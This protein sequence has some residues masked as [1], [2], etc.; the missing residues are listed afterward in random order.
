M[1]D[2]PLL[3]G[4]SS[5]KG[6]HEWLRGE[7]HLKVMGDAGYRTVFIPGGSDRDEVAKWMNRADLF[8]SGQ[9][10]G[11]LT[12]PY[13][14][15]W[16]DMIYKET[17]R[18][19]PIVWDLDDNPDSIS[20]WNSSYDTF[21]TEEVEI[22]NPDTGVIRKLWEDGVSGFDLVRNRINLEAYRFMLKSADALTVPQPYLRDKVLKY[23]QNVEILPNY[24]D[25]KTH[26]RLRNK[27]QR[28]G[29][30]RILYMGGS[31]HFMDWKFIAPVMKTLTRQYPHIRVV[32]YGNSATWARADLGGE[33]VED[34]R[35]DGNYEAFC[36]KMGTLGV[37]IG[38]A[39]LNM[40]EHDREF[41]RCKSPLK[42]VDYGAV[43]IPCVAQNDHPYAPVINFG[44]G[45]PD[46]MWDG[47]LA[48]TH[49]DWLLALSMLIENP[50]LRELIGSNAY[51]TIYQHWN[52]ATKAEEYH[53]IYMRILEKAK[54]HGPTDCSEI[55]REVSFA[56]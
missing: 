24:V 55:T 6:A 11:V 14:Y 26:Y 10:A 56:R 50:P 1:K 46:I 5:L 13:Y 9:G 16:R 53:A 4:H 38:I 51:Q 41:N 29:K 43:G 15:Q 30:V 12:V 49:A 20:P 28:D 48:S 23:N 36:L 39:P 54:W 22:Q 45:I 7:Q 21:G 44:P 35:V 2:N 18:Y 8:T 47:L 34:M 33:F 37:D 52:S 3:V 17:G 40:D 31:S 27:P 32:C 25:F 42:W 19:V